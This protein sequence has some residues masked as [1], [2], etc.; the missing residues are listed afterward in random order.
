MRTDGTEAG[1]RKAKGFG[2]AISAGITTTLQLGRE[3]SH[4]AAHLRILSAS[5]DIPVTRATFPYVMA[6]AATRW[7]S[8]TSNQKTATHSH[9]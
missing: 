9:A 3:L 8:P 5:R 1:L 4:Y 6:S 7:S 2:P